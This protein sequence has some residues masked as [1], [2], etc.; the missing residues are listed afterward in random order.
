[1]HAP[2]TWASA[3]LCGSAPSSPRSLLLEGKAEV[4]QQRPALIVVAGRCDDRDVHAADPV[5]P[6]LVDLV[7]HRLLVET[8]RVVAAAV[9][10][11]RRE[12]AEVAD[13]RQGDRRKPVE[14]LP[15]SVATQRSVRADGHTLTQL[16]LGDGL[17]CPGDRR[18]L[19]GDDL[20]VADGA[21]DQLGVAGGVADTHVD[22]DLRDR[23]NL[24]DVGEAELLAQRGQ[25]LLAVALL[26]PRQRPGPGGWRLSRGSHQMSLPVR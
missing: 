7:E 15:H 2:R 6:V 10:L 25:D 16:E 4:P 20:E 22:H 14:E 1:M 9:E 26:E 17:P 18:L 8:E 19:A 21:L 13:T 24:H 3:S 23:G 12:A 5:D 11:P